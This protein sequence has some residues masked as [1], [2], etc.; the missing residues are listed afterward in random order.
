MSE[1]VAERQSFFETSDGQRIAKSGLDADTLADFQTQA[2]IKEEEAV[3]QQAAEAQQPAPVMEEQQFSVVPEETIPASPVITPEHGA[4]TELKGIPEEER[5]F[6]DEFGKQREELKKIRAPMMQVGKPEPEIKKPGPAP[7]RPV[8]PSLEKYL[9]PQAREYIELKSNIAKGKTPTIETIG[10][11]EFGPVRLPGRTMTPAEVQAKLAKLQ[12][13]F[14][15]AL[16]QQEQ[17]AVAMRPALDAFR[18]QEEEYE[19]QKA[20]YKTSVP[21]MQE[22][23][24]AE[25]EEFK[26]QTQAQIEYVQ[27][28][29][30]RIQKENEAIKS[31]KINP[32]RVWSSPSG[33]VSAALFIAGASLTAFGSTLSRM[34]D[35]NAGVRIMQQFVERDI[36]LQQQEIDNKKEGVKELRNELESQQGMWT[37]VTAAYNA[38]RSHMMTSI[39]MKIEE[40][41]NKTN[42]QNK[43]QALNLQAQ[44]INLEAERLVGESL[45]D[46]AGAR[47]QLI[48]AANPK[49]PV[50]QR[51]E[52][53]E[54]SSYS[55]AAQHSTELM[56]TWKQ[57]YGKDLVPGENVWNP[58]TNVWERYMPGRATPQKDMDRISSLFT[59]ML[60][61]AIAGARYSD[62]DLRMFIG[63]Q[64]KPTDSY[65]EGLRKIKM[66]QDEVNKQARNMFQAYRDAGKHLKYIDAAEST[67][68]THSNKFDQISHFPQK[69]EQ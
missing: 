38:Q 62:T 13:H 39:G 47:M 41:A 68:N 15:S 11:D 7:E 65:E 6:L 44:Q 27:E 63:M 8:G 54:I 18:E 60:A 14:E 33:L 58:V 42:D 19:R 3:E 17:A 21:G 23:L 26:K 16:A 5:G 1:I 48:K 30:L 51:R 22:Q 12:P 24:Q 37:S 57:V 56:S 55:L 52:I 64:V 2:R 59:A 20:A 36:A 53:E 34:G 61:K 10:N 4:T 29:H 31:M 49:Q 46:E 43:K 32:N 67:Y 35:P 50:I 66:V 40:A 45:K 9:N 69:L 28:Q 25:H